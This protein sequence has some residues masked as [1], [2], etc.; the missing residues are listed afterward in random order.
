MTNFEHIELV[1][2]EHRV[3]K[4]LDEVYNY[5]YRFM[6]IYLLPAFKAI[7]KIFIHRVYIKYLGF[8]ST[9]KITMLTC[10]KY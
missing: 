6:S 3:I 7:S 4:Y 1:N 5:K 10:I 8:K 9:P 2:F